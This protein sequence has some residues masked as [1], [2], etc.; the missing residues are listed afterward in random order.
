MYLHGQDASAQNV[1]QSSWQ[2]GYA[3]VALLVALSVMGVLMSVALP[4]WKQMTQ[5]EKEEELIF[6]GKQYARAIGLFQRRAGPGVLPPN[7][8]VLVEQRFLRKKFKDPITNDD[9][10]PLLAGQALPGSPTPGGPTQP[11]SPQGRGSQQTPAGRGQ[12]APTGRGTTF[13]QAPGQIPGT[14]GA[15]A[16]GGGVPGGVVKS[17]EKSIRVYEGRTRYNEWTFVF[18]PQ[19]QAPGG[20]GGR[21]QAPGVG[22]PTGPG[23]GGRG[24]RGNSPTP[25][26]GFPPPGPGGGFP[27]GPTPRGGSPGGAAPGAP[28][29]GGPRPAPAP[30]P[31]N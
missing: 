7:L 12:T 27:G 22:Q 13:G 10:Q 14:P 11:G 21:G 28:F 8:D 31:G 29:P 20:A 23:V 26:G 19:V 1:T 4:A 30:G 3:M 9:F 16:G 25:R 17:K 18:V 24:G 2:D 15:A 6:R 5:R